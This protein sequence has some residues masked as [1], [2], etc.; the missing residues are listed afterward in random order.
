MLKMKLRTKVG[1]IFC[2]D[3]IELYSDTRHQGVPNY[4]LLINTD[5]THKRYNSFR[6]VN[7]VVLRPHVEGIP[8]FSLLPSQTKVYLLAMK[9]ALVLHSIVFNDPV[10]WVQVVLAIGNSSGKCPPTGK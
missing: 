8:D 5:D 1:R 9:G 2:T 6:K 7:L 10:H 4:C 3:N